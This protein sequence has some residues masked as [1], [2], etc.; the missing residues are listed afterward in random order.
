MA[1]WD[2]TFSLF[3]RLERSLS[4]CAVHPPVGG[5]FD[6]GYC[7]FVENNYSLIVNL[8]YPRSACWSTRS[9]RISPLDSPAQPFIV[10]L[11]WRLGTTS[12]PRFLSLFFFRHMLT[13]VSVPSKSS[14]TGDCYSICREVRSTNR[15]SAGKPARTQKL[16]RT[17]MV[18]TTFT[19]NKR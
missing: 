12:A 4:L 16:A 5:L 2:R 15:R 3:C 1:F 11:V 17:R 6:Q 9:P 19:Q 14:N 8:G 18:R 7:P 13:S 10:V